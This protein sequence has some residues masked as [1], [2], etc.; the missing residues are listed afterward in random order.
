[1]SGFSTG[2]LALREPADL[3]A[4]NL[5]LAQDLFGRLGGR[6]RLHVV[7]L[8]AGTGAN[9]RATA[10]LLGRLQTWH[11]LDHDPALLSEAARALSD[12]ADTA[13]DRDGQL[14]LQKADRQITVTFRQVDLAR[15]PE[16]AVEGD[17]DLVTASAFFD[18]VSAAWIERFVDAVVGAGAHFF[19]V[20][21]C[22][23]RDAWTPPHEADASIAAAFRTHQGHDKG[24]GPGAGDVATDLLMHAFR[25]RGYAG[26]SRDSPW[27]LDGANAADAALIAALAEGTATAAGETGQVLAARVA[28]WR[29]ARITASQCRIGHMDILAWP[30]TA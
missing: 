26:H 13:Q 20:L 2:W 25:Q 28:A 8:G 1:M 24:F 27:L 14:Q 12:W 18:L 11:L 21:T 10:P 15:H 22:D 30:K 9:L 7:D 6:E 3:R 23:G 16:A 19:T 5:E 17:P 29:A 4:R